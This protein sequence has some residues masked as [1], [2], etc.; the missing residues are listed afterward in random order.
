MVSFILNQQKINTNLPFD[1]KVLD[2]LRSQ[3]HITSTKAGC[4]TGR[5]GGQGGQE[6]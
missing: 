3:Q 6:A 1:T 4:H 2:F 5:C